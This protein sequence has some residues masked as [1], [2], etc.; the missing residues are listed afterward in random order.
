MRARAL[1]IASKIAAPAGSR[2]IVSVCTLVLILFAGQASAEDYTMILQPGV[3]GDPGSVLSLAASG[4]NQVTIVKRVDKLSPALLQAVAAGTTFQAVDFV[5]FDTTFFAPIEV[6]TFEF[7]NV[8]FTSYLLNPNVNSPTET[9]TFIAETS[10]FTPA[11]TSQV[12]GPEG[13]PGPA[14]PQGPQGDVG[15]AGP[16]G[17]IGPQG[18]TGAT[19]I[20]LAFDIRRI[21]ADTV[22]TMPPDTHS[23]V[24]LV[25]TTQHPVTITLPLA[26]TAASRFVTVTRVDPGSRVIVQPQG[27]DALEGARAPIVMGQIYDSFTMISDGHEWV[28]WFRRN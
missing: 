11:Q 6:G 3:T 18:P 22:I 27:N 24:Y 5:A 28:V 14:G 12:P 9:I 17:P 19:G 16:M 21:S 8:L 2:S 1:W 4:L 23:V 26:S 7:T 13:P 25:T 15:P 10:T 20:G